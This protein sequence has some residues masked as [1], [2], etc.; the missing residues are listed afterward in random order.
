MGFRSTPEYLFGLEAEQSVEQ[1][2]IDAGAHVIA[3]YTREE[4]DKPPRMYGPDG[5][6]VLPDF[7]VYHPTGAHLMVEVKRKTAPTVYRIGGDIPQHGIDL[8]LYRQYR[9]V[10]AITRTEV[11]LVVRESSTGWAGCG[12]L[13]EIPV[14]H[15]RPFNSYGNG[16]MV[17]FNRD[18][19]RP[20]EAL[21]ARLTGGDVAYVTMATADTT[22]EWRIGE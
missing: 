15:E 18:E 20:L 22:T 17:Y 8:R 6:L 19:F 14:D 16:G 1:Y 12:H 4:E 10:E 2:L 3:Q 11:W 5:C 9:R 13:P 21:R 7:D